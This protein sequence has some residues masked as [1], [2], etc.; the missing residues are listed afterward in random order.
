MISPSVRP[1]E[2]D[3]V[4]VHPTVRIWRARLATVPTAIRVARL[5]LARP[6]SLAPS[7]FYAGKDVL[8]ATGNHEFSTSGPR[9]DPPILPDIDSDVN[10]TGAFIPP[11]KGVGVRLTFL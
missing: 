7:P 8:P 5:V 9:R 3:P 2:D 6:S 11:L 10:R 1:S 4:P